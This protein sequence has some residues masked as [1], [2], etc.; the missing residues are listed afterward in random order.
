MDSRLRAVAFA[1][2]LIGISSLT[3]VQ[4]LQNSVASA[5]EG[6]VLT[7]PLDD[8]MPLQNVNSTLTSNQT[9]S[10]AT[11]VSGNVTAHN[12]TSILELSST[13]QPSTNE[14]A[15]I[16]YLQYQMTSMNDQLVAMSSRIN[17]MSQDNGTAM[18][19]AEAGLIV[20]ILAVIAAIAVA[21]RADALYRESS[22]GQTA[23]ST[24][25]KK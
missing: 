10:S 15:A 24:P 4:A 16:S 5:K 9:I 21:R 7:L 6:R 12:S 23:D 13:L 11:M 3:F 18:L 20:G 22:Q 2:L 25:P 8:T 17:S 19:I 1:V 14:T